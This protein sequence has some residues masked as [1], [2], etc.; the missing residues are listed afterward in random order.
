MILRLKRW[1]I[2]PELDVKK[3]I[4]ERE[5]DV[6]AMLMLNDTSLSDEAFLE[7]V[8]KVFE[9]DVSDI[10]S[11]IGEMFQSDAIVKKELD[12]NIREY[13]KWF[14]SDNYFYLGVRRYGAYKWNWRDLFKMFKNK[15][16]E[17]L[18]L[19]QIK[20]DIKERKYV[21]TDIGTIGEVKDITKEER[22]KVDFI[23]Q[24]Y[25]VNEKTR[26]LKT[27]LEKCDLTKISLEDMGLYKEWLMP[28]I[29]KHFTMD[30]IRSDIVGLI[31]VSEHALQVYKNVFDREKKYAEL[32]SETRFEEEM[33][34]LENSQA[35]SLARR[36]DN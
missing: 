1:T 16:E 20:K 14:S 15:K 35:I 4:K 9:L 24:V 30:K 11:L 28:I 27:E 26:K 5:L 8:S 33:Q 25:V 13:P 7:I 6:R 21:F 36:L 32:M 3:Q 10:D 23:S 18:S 19:E 17:K 34:N 29:R 22:E 2:N 12:T 31:R